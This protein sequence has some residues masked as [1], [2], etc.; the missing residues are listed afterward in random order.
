MSRIYIIMYN[1]SGFAVFIS[2]SLRHN[3]LRHNSLRH[4]SLRH[5]SLRQA[6][7]VV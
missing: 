5:S 6:A 1:V 3:S 2:C 4:S 7:K